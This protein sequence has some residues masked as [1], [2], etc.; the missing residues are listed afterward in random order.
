MNKSIFVNQKYITRFSKKVVC[1]KFAHT[2]DQGLKNSKKLNV[3][4]L[5]LNVTNSDFN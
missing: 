2:T 4:Y 5:N 1:A 3:D